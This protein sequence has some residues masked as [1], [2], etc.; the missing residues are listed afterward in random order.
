MV[1]K[2]PQGYN[3]AD[4]AQRVQNLPPVK[5]S[6]GINLPERFKPPTIA[7]IQTA[8][9]KPERAESSGGVGG[10]F[11][12]ALDVLDYGRAGIVST[13]K[14]GIDLAQGEG[15]NFGEWKNQVQDHY[16]FGDL[17]HDEREWVG[18]GMM[19]LAPFNPFL[20]AAGGAVL[21]DNIWADRVIGFIGDV[22]VDPL[23]Y[24]SGFTGIVRNLGGKKMRLIASDLAGVGTTATTKTAKEAA[25]IAAE[26]IKKSK[27]K[28]VKDMPVPK[29]EDIQ[30]VL[31]ETIG[32]T[33]K[34]GGYTT[35]AFSRALNAKGPV[36]QLANEML[37]LSAGVRLRIPGTGPLARLGLRQFID[38]TGKVFSKNADWMTERMVAK[39]PPAMRAGFED[40]DLVKAVNYFKG[41]R[42][43]SRAGRQSIERQ[44]GEEVG[45]RLTQVAGAAARAPLEVGPM[46]ARRAGQVAFGASLINR[47]ADLPVRGFN[48]VTPDKLQDYL[49]VKFNP[50]W[51]DPNKGEMGISNLL[52]SEDP[53]RI[54][55]GLRAEQMQRAAR[56]TEKMFVSEIDV[57]TNRMKNRAD[58]SKTSYDDLTDL[59]EVPPNA[60]QVWFDE[61]PE[62][63]QILARDN[64]EAFGKLRNE[65]NK[66][67]GTTTKH[68]TNAYGRVNAFGKKVWDQAE[69][70]VAQEGGSWRAPRVMVDDMKPRYIENYSA[71]DPLDMST[72]RAIHGR[73]VPA[74]VKD[75]TPWIGDTIP[76][77]GDDAIEAS[78]TGTVGEGYV[79]LRDADGNV[80]RKKT[81]TVLLNPDTGRP[82]VYQDP[83]VV[84]K[85]FRRQ[86]NEASMAAYG[87]NMHETN[88]MQLNTSYKKGMGRDI[89]VQNFMKDLREMYPTE[90][91][92]YLLKDIEGSVKQ[93]GDL[94][95]E[96][97]RGVKQLATEV[98]KRNRILQKIN[99]DRNKVARKRTALL[100]L[101]PDGRQASEVVEEMDN[102]IWDLDQQ[103]N[104]IVEEL[105]VLGIDMSAFTTPR[106]LTESVEA[107]GKR[108]LTDEL[109]EIKVTEKQWREQ[110]GPILEKNAKTAEAVDAVEELLT[111]LMVVREQLEILIREEMMLADDGVIRAHNASLTLDEE[112]RIFEDAQKLARENET[113]AKRAEKSLERIDEMIE[114]QRLRVDEA[115]AGVAAI[116]AEN[117]S[118]A[119]ALDF[120]QSVTVT[121]DVT[122][123]NLRNAGVGGKW[124]LYGSNPEG[125]IGVVRVRKGNSYQYYRVENPDGAGWRWFGDDQNLVTGLTDWDAQKKLLRE[126][127]GVVTGGDKPVPVARA[128]NIEDKAI[129]DLEALQVRREK[130][131]GEIA[132]GAE[133]PRLSQMNFSERE[134]LI[135]T[136]ESMHNLI[137]STID[138]ARTQIKLINQGAVVAAES[139]E[140]V[141]A[142]KDIRDFLIRLNRGVG[143]AESL[144]DPVKRVRIWKENV[145]TVNDLYDSTG[146][147]SMTAGTRD[148][149]K[150]A[151]ETAAE[152][153]V[154]FNERT[155]GLSEQLGLTRSQ[156]EVGGVLYDELKLVDQ[157][158]DL[159]Y[160]IAQRN[161]L[162]A[163][164]NRLNNAIKQ[165][166]SA[167][168][169]SDGRQQKLLESQRQV[170][171]L[172]AK[173]VDNEIAA[174][175]ANSALFETQQRV[176]TLLGDLEAT[177]QAAGTTTKG[178]TIG[179]RKR[180]ADFDDLVKR[181]VGLDQEGADFLATDAS[182]KTAM[183]AIK[184]SLVASEWGPWALLSGDT[185]LNRDMNAVIQTFAKINDPV[186]VDGFWKAWDK[187]QT[188]LKAGMIATPGFV[189]RNIFGAFFNA[190]LD[191][192]NLNE[193]F[194]SAQITTRV[195]RQASKDKSSFMD[196]AYKLRRTNKD[197]ADYVDFLEAGV[198]GGGQAVSAFELETGLRNARTMRFLIGERGRVELRPWKPTFAPFAAVRTVNSWV[199]DIIRIGVGMDTVRWGGTVND[200]LERIAKSQFDYDELTG[201]EREWMRRFFPFYT[202]TRKNVPYQLQQIGAN[203][204]KFNKL[205]AAKRNLE[206]GTEEE[207]VVPDYYL[208]PFGI[209]LPI[210]FKGAQVYTAPDIPFQDLGRYDPFRGGKDG[211]KE[212]AKAAFGMTSPIIKAPL[213]VAF[214]K[215]MFTGIPFSGR[216]QRTP[217]A[218]TIIP[219]L[220]DILSSVGMAKKAPTGEWKMRDHHV[221]L[222][223]GLLPSIGVIRRMFPNE[224]KYQRNHVR[225]LISTLGGVSVN[226]NTPQVQQNW[227]AN[228]KYEKLDES[229]DLKDLIRKDR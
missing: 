73:L 128:K 82:F 161:S 142:L 18:Y 62:E 218:I 10:L 175:N 121:G 27:V 154:A 15:F 68:T 151:Q 211:W 202:W 6:V 194:K 145:K 63:L 203:P 224:P 37:G 14:E 114:E 35:T 199:E 169:I 137:K 90:D 46:W 22:G 140:S 1:Y 92:D 127:Y 123:F 53:V 189:Q 34:R 85:S 193:I 57:A 163:E 64:P 227:V 42:A 135:A 141:K 51:G 201:F 150:K 49:A 29:G 172:A 182:R 66:W 192:V 103:M 160:L 131:V 209:R 76:V 28:N 185:A 188:W 148:F 196:A 153:L 110:I 191:G 78:R 41:S 124:K 108:V 214:G 26:T 117:A 86:A 96:T 228:Q 156:A 79:N 152:E 130:K 52:Y 165:L 197:M 136:F 119:Q 144:T 109:E 116:D 4:L 94:A 143:G 45:Q 77:Y 107:R 40:R 88:M 181:A 67:V 198:R 187:T 120:Q 186:Q 31:S 105:S 39:I 8:L 133:P 38:R 166:E 2:P 89:R 13:L 125:T 167:I 81:A 20:I 221:Y 226:F 115:R 178:A 50:T 210:K 83:N 168:K 80:L 180:A 129:R 104:D 71:V 43:A 155:V 98:A 21:A 25:D 184:D 122:N 112:V 208:E 183:K 16:G 146:H 207:G 11:G 177:A 171:I 47:A 87:R 216:Y 59:I 113:K 72:G 212:T 56:H 162:S 54:S 101:T 102:Y 174:A 204:S 206:L 157:I 195:A 134:D 32:E 61:L 5:P 179:S 70:V 219:G 215:N 95:K 222:I 200:G 30:R 138:E 217:K 158:P 173:V 48:K 93:F 75:R 170:A 33:G 111:N 159:E 149:T 36:G 126:E 58:L 19:A 147:G 164:R 205:L 97:K 84:G 99:K 118:L 213:E 91:L 17:I 190:W 74:H 60:S 223:Q 55:L 220:V 3:R 69:K 100:K 139:T 7:P 132:A 229:Q 225:N 9:P 24:I 176:Q 44:F 106:T 23:A 65:G 12:L